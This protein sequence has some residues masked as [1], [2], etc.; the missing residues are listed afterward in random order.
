MRPRE[1]P[2]TGKKLKN[3]LVAR[4]GLRGEEGIEA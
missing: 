1:D 2:F 3:R 4:A